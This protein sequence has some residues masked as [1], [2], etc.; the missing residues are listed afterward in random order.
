MKKT[1]L[2]LLITPLLFFPLVLQAEGLSVSGEDTVQSILS[3]NQ[4]KRVIIRLVSGGEL[5]GKVGT[6]NGKVVHLMEL[7]GR[8]F[9]DAVVSLDQIEAVIIRTRQ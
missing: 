9:F 4:D 1:L 8:E 6:V 7:S 5:T 3:A 2:A